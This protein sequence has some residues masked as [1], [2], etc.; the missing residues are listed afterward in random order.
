MLTNGHNGSS[1]TN[2]HDKSSCKGVMNGGYENGNSNCHVNNAASVT[3][4][5]E[6]TATNSSS[7]N[8]NV[9]CSIG[10]GGGVGGVDMVGPQKASSPLAVKMT[11]GQNGHS[12][13]IN[14]VGLSF[15]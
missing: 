3:D 15:I 9:S 6:A 4:D 10:G 7:S 11:N 2:G 8:N 13:P 12:V 5:D 14:N 1:K